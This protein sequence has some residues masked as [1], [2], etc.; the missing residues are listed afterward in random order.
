M[1]YQICNYYHSHVLK[2]NRHYSTCN[3]RNAIFI[4]IDGRLSKSNIDN[5]S[6]CTWDYRDGEEALPE[7]NEFQTMETNVY[8]F[9]TTNDEQRSNCC[10]KQETGRPQDFYVAIKAAN[11][12]EDKILQAYVLHVNEGNWKLYDTHHKVR[13]GKQTHIHCDISFK[14]SIYTYTTS[15]F[16]I[17]IPFLGKVCGIQSRK[18]ERIFHPGNIYRKRFRCPSLW[19]SVYPRNRQACTSRVP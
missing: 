18:G 11:Q 3:Y 4:E 8:C 12:T 14:K 6:S 9:E 13:E 10:A 7:L 16:Y 1:R 5:L 19:K 15:F 17:T 2:S